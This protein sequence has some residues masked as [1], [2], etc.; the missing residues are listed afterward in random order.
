[1]PM[2]IQSIENY[3]DL[4]FPPNLI[5]NNKVVSFYSFDNKTPGIPPAEHELW[6]KTSSS[7]V[8]N[9]Q[10]LL[11]WLMTTDT[12]MTSPGHEILGKI[13]TT[14]HCT[15]SV[16]IN[17][18]WCSNNGGQ[19]R[20]YYFTNGSNQRVKLPAGWTGK[21]LFFGQNG[22]AYNKFSMP[23]DYA[24]N[25]WNA[26]GS[27]HSS[28]IKID[29]DTSGYLQITPSPPSKG[30]STQA[31]GKF[32]NPDQRPGLQRLNKVVVQLPGGQSS[33]ARNIWSAGAN[34]TLAKG[35]KMYLNRSKISGASPPI[36][37]GAKY[38]A[39]N[40]MGYYDYPNPI[41]VDFSFLD[42][43]TDH[44]DGKCNNAYWAGLGVIVIT[45]NDKVPTT[46]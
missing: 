36:G 39:V 29:G 2:L 9:N 8:T 5:F 12:L 4:F 10:T 19:H 17:G 40:V 23:I 31:S 28:S 22:T 16:L 11:P 7:A 18:G 38:H 35:I 30:Y 45:T 14:L 21:I 24:Q 6:C 32:Y 26:D 44:H 37:P 42:H 43:D 1:M 27:C 13:Y 46:Y 34:P 3:G 25:L 41:P 15:T 20:S 33:N